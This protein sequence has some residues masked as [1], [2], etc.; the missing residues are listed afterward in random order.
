MFTE[1]LP[2]I[3]EL[4]YNHFAIKPQVLKFYC[5]FNCEGTILELLARTCHSYFYST[6]FS[7][8]K[9][10]SFLFLFLFSPP[11]H[12]VYWSSDCLNVSVKETYSLWDGDHIL[13]L[14]LIIFNHLTSF[15]HFPSGNMCTRDEAME[16]ENARGFFI[17][18]RHEISNALQA[19]S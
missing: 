16:D 6:N 5:E 11:C 19:V 9:K 15:W 12:G 4:S 1:V 3:Q 8:I 18:Q 17:F 10:L 14:L 7:S 2:I 13:P